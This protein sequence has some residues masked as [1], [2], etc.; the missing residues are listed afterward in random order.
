MADY[1]QTYTIVL[2]PD[3]NSWR[4]Y[5]LEIPECIGKGKG[6]QAA[7]RVVKEAIRAY[8]RRRL[9]A[10]QPLPQRDKVIKFPR[11]DLRELGWVAEEI[12]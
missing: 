3:Q 7:Y 4:G 12:R 6:R 2:E 9:L 1:T 8:L 11:F 5:C 10:K